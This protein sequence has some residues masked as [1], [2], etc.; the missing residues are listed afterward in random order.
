MADLEEIHI[1]ERTISNP[2]DALPAVADI[3]ANLTMQHAIISNVRL[4]PG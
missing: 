1:M 2:L 4:T 3:G